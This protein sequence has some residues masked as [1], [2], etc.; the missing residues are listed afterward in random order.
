[1]RE[2]TGMVI[3]EHV[4]KFVL[5]DVSFCVP[6]GEIVGVIGASGAGKTTLLKLVCGLLEAESG[7][8]Y[9]FRQKPVLAGRRIGKRMAALFADIPVLGEDTVVR[10]GLEDY[11]QI[12]GIG[13]DEFARA[14]ARLGECLGFAAYGDLPVRS[15]SL[16]QRRRAELGTVFL[17]NPELI[18]LDEPGIGLDQSARNT[19]HQLLRER[20]AAGATILISSHDMDEIAGLCGRILMLDEGRRLFYGTRELL[21]R[22]YAPMDVCELD[23]EYRGRLPEVADLPIAHYEF[24]RDQLVIVFNSNHISAAEILSHVMAQ[25]QLR[26]VTVRKGSLL[27]SIKNIAN[28]REGEKAYEFD[29]GEQYL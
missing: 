10:Q 6:K 26:A 23:F 28:R 1:M 19:L 22:K 18:I 20:Q 27:D 8:V 5:K 25:T 9:T 16:G 15:L 7:G 4:S 13:Q 3:F 2:E 24:K 17:R 21:L 12:Y 11:R 29:R 14:C